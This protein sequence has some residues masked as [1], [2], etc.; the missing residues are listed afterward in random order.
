[1]NFWRL[2]AMSSLQSLTAE[3]KAEKRIVRNLTRHI[4]NERTMTISIAEGL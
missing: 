4:I 1:M 3:L 2:Q